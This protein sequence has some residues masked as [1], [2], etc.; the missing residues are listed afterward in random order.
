MRYV[1]GISKQAV[2]K[3]LTP[4]TDRMVV[5]ASFQYTNGYLQVIAPAFD[6]FSVCEQSALGLHAIAEIAGPALPRALEICSELRASIASMPSS[7]R[8][9]LGTVKKPGE[10]LRAL[11]PLVVRRR[12]IAIV[13]HI[14]QLVQKAESAGGAVVFASGAFFRPLCGIRPEPGGEYDS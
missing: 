12:A 4:L 14:D 2:E 8:I 1:L 3:G 7:W 5:N 11:E 9:H 13:D 6:Q 10:P